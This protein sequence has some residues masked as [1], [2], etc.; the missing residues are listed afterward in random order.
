MKFTLWVIGIAM[1]CTT[2]SGADTSV[3]ATSAK[4]VKVGDATYYLHAGSD[5]ECM[6]TTLRDGSTDVT[7][8]DG[9]NAAV[10]NSVHGCLDSAGDG[11]CGRNVPYRSDLSGSQ[12]NC[13]DGKSYSITSGVISDNHCLF[14][15]DTKICRTLDAERYAE[16]TCKDGCGNTRRG[17]GC[18]RISDRGCPLGI[19][20]SMRGVSGGRP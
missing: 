17:G 14:T 9:I 18:C 11:Y 10:L 6:T 3:K 20:H 15:G 16:A 5:N 4:S 1:C 2:A 7:C 13:P 12:L 8:S 19:L